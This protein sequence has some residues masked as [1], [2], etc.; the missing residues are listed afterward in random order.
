MVSSNFQNQ[1]MDNSIDK[2]PL[3]KLLEK[4]HAPQHSVGLLNVVGLSYAIKEMLDAAK[5]VIRLAPSSAELSN[6]I[7]VLEFGLKLELPDHGSDLDS[8][9]MRQ[10]YKEYPLYSLFTQGKKWGDGEEI[11]ASVPVCKVLDLDEFES[12]SDILGRTHTG[13]KKFGSD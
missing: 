13:M 11:H 10:H 6:L 12:A 3:Y 4:I 1:A 8:N 2:E 7:S 9:P 5:G